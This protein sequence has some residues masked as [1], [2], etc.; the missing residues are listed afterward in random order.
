MKPFLAKKYVN[1]RMPGKWYTIDRAWGA[2][3]EI[4][5]YRNGQYATRLSITE[6]EYPVWVERLERGGWKIAN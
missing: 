6:S 5:E 3:Y 2:G 1:D 4:K